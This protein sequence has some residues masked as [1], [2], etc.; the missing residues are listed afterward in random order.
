MK[1]R[2]DADWK[3][4]I[5]VVSCSAKIMDEVKEKEGTKIIKSM[6]SY[7]SRLLDGNNIAEIS[8]PVVDDS[9]NY[10]SNF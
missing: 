3:L 10:S 6:L 9:R 7:F 2:F 4:V 8:G 5:T 1:I